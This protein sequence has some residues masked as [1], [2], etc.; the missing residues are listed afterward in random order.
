MACCSAY[1]EATFEQIALG[2]G[3]SAFYT[4]PLSTAQIKELVAKLH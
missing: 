4:K 2:A 1:T 3:I